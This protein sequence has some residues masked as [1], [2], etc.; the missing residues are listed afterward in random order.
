MHNVLSSRDSSLG[1]SFH[2][3]TERGTARLEYN[4]II[5]LM[6]LVC[7]IDSE[8]PMGKTIIINIIAFFKIKFV[9]Q[10]DIYCQ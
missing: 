6:S 10:R 3:R 8:T 7:N 4:I 2:L 1:F 9:V 5:L